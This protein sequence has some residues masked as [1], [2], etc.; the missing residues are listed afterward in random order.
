MIRCVQ[1]KELADIKWYI[2]LT[3]ALLR[4][5]ISLE[6]GTITTT[7]E[8]NMTEKF[9]TKGSVGLIRNA[10]QRHLNEAISTDIDPHYDVRLGNCNYTNEIATFKL[11][12]TFQG[13]SELDIREKN[14]R[15]AMDMYAQQFDIDPTKIHGE[16]KLV[17]FNTRA[18]R[19][20]WIMENKEGER[21]VVTS[22]VAKQMFGNDT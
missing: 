6:A 7:M 19:T 3:E 13:N 20:P 1:S 11:I 5:L 16:F 4:M 12:V 2:L 22:P 9:F 18:K 15:Y 21:F 17:G 8:V 10:L 14:Q